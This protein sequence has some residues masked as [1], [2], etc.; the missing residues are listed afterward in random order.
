MV[1]RRLRKNRSMVAGVRK[2]GVVETMDYCMWKLETIG[3]LIGCPIGSS[4]WHKR[5]KET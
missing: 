3:H 5:K 1:R 4:Y 2:T